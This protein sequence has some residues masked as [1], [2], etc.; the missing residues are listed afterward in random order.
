M[1]ASRCSDALDRSNGPP[2]ANSLAGRNALTRSLRL[3][4]RRVRQN[5]PRQRTRVASTN[6]V[7]TAIVVIRT[8]AEA[9]DF[10]IAAGGPPMIATAWMPTMTASQARHCRRRDD[11][12]YPDRPRL[13]SETPICLSAPSA[14]NERSPHIGLGPV[15]LHCLPVPAAPVDGIVATWPALDRCEL[16][17]SA[18]RPSRHQSLQS[19][20]GWSYERLCEPERKV[21]RRA[22][23]ENGSTV[24]AFCAVCGEPGGSQP[25]PGTA[26]ATRPR[27]FAPP[28]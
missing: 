19:T 12:R 21:F 1:R 6:S 10:F 24:D 4:S 23:F 27:A 17:Q 25:R 9:Q 7:P 20:I 11:G 14:L 18:A 15:A 5:Q 2:G 16:S 3:P 22:V 13:I 28:D 26:R 8:H